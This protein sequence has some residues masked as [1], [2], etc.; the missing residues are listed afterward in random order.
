MQEFS[1]FLQEVSFLSELS[2][3][4]QKFFVVCAGAIAFSTS[5]VIVSAE[6][7]VI[8]AKDVIVSVRVVFISPRVVVVS[9][10][11][12]VFAIVC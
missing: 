7:A 1:T 5:V 2:S 11:V 6:E 10:G 3:S 4:L 9:A 8:S 12:V